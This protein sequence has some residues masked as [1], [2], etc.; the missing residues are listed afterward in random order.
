MKAAIVE[1]EAEVRESVAAMLS[2]I[3]LP[4]EAFA[5]AGPFLASVRAGAAYD[6]CIADIDL[7]GMRGDD[8]L[9]ELG[10]S[11]QAGETAIL[12]L[13]GLEADELERARR[14]V[15]AFFHVVDYSCK[16]IDAGCLLERIEALITR[17]ADL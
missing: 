16:P 3:G 12:F 17:R 9:L 14:K 7:P 6:L 15:R 10:R 11:R 8:M 4:S 1:D 2:T 5:S 13:S